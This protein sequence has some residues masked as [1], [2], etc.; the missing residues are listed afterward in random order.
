MRV[1]R[2]AGSGRQNGRMPQPTDGDGAAAAEADPDGA[3]LDAVADDLYGLP[4]AEFTGARNAR[5]AASRPPLSKRIAALRKPVAAAFAVNL[6]AR[7]GQLGEA[8]ELS[9]ALREAQD[10]L[11]AAELSRLGG[12]RRALVGALA[13]R[14][15]D[16]AA[17]QGVAVSAATKDAI[18]KTINAAVMDAGA[19]AAV[20]TGRL[21]AP[22]EAGAF[23]PADLDAAVGGSVPGIVAPPPRDDLA[24]RRARRAAE[25]AA[26]EADR[27]ASEAEREAARAGAARASAQERV[28]HLDE[29][30]A[31]LRRDLDRVEADAESAR[32]KLADLDRRASA[33]ASRAGEARRQADAAQRNVPEE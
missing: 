28:D 22:L 33:A 25:K 5:A 4:P 8:L 9:A 27:A 12:Q 20:M 23:E 7:D 24:Q 2:S 16:L 15:A 3:D 31:E 13:A 26:R 6:L 18:A 32:Q 19:A 10:D 1:C 30:A 17:S 29:R 11:D 14:A 21:V